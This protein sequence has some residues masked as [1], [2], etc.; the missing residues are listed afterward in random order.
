MRNK[1]L[2]LISSKY[3]KT[4]YIL[5][6]EINYCVYF[7]TDGEYVKIGIAASLP[8]RMKQLQTGNAR[9]LKAIY[10]INA[11]TQIDALKIEGELHKEFKEKQCIGEWF[12]IKEES[13]FPICRK[14]GYILYKPASKFNFDVDGI[15]N[16]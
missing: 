2:G 5:V 12:N 13:I 1:M 11:E 8:N 7:I 15:E 16:I 14:L 6:E 10:I 9:K 4:K 3:L